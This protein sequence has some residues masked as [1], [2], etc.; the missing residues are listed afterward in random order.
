MA[1]T[2][3]QLARGR[4]KLDAYRRWRHD[5]PRAYAC[6]ERFAIDALEAGQHT[7]GRAIVEHIRA[8]ELTDEHGKPTRTSNNHAAI[9]AREFLRNHPQYVERM[10]LRP[11]EFP[12]LMA[13]GGTNA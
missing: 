10:E 2:D 3:E 5:N 1:Y 6:G 8:H 9:I 7:S 13:G 4:R 11:S 12:V